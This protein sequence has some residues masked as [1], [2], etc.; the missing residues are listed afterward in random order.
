M[1]RLL[2]A[3]GAITDTSKP[4]LITLE[5]LEAQI[6]ALTPRAWWDA[7]NP[8]Y[9]I[10]IG[11][12]GASITGSIA[13]TTL[14]VSAVASGAVA[15]G[16]AVTGAG[17]TAGTYIT[18]G[19]GT[20]WTVS[21][22]QTIASETLN[23][24]QT[25]SQVNDRSGN[26]FNLLQGTQANRPPITSNYWGALNSVSRDALTFNGTIP[27]QMPSAG[28][29]FDGTTVWTEVVIMHDSGAAIAIVISSVGSANLDI[30]AQVNA[31][32]WRQNGVTNPAVTAQTADVMV[33]SC[34]NYPGSGN[35]TGTIYSADRGGAI[36][37]ATAS[38]AVTGIM[39]GTVPALVGT[40]GASTGFNFNGMISEIL[41]FKSD[42]SAN[43]AAIA[44]L[45]QYYQMKYRT[46]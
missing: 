36:I 11:G 10:D 14:T 41:I 35:M 39:P 1:T 4:V 40:W 20:S 17:V 27:Y 12:S 32:T 8:V 3:D 43:P 25:C 13:A 19:S 2:K 6:A 21:A 29:V 9:R 44:L 23:L 34:S 28:N 30:V 37:S 5:S 16:Q 46:A 7:S 18:A 24:L 42:L 26:G 45:N 22:S 33:I 31:R 38:Y 15:I